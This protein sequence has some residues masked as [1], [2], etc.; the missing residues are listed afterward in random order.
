MVH[1]PA[2]KARGGTAAIAPLI[3]A[4]REDLRIRQWRALLLFLLASAALFALL[5]LTTVF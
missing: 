1:E 4:E 2:S 3:R 5:L